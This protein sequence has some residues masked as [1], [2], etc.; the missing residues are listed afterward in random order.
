MSALVSVLK[1]LL[2]SGSAL[3]KLGHGTLV[4]GSRIRKMTECCVE[5][6]DMVVCHVE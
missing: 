3:P 1:R 2:Y 5:Q 4:S 6:K